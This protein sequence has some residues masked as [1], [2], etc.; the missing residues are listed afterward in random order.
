MLTL[1]V[2]RLMLPFASRKNGN[3]QLEAATVFSLAMLQ[4][5]RGKGLFSRQPQEKLSFVTSTAY[6]LWLFPRNNSGLIFDGLKR[7][8]HSVAYEEAPS[9]LAFMDN[10]MKNQRPRETFEAFLSDNNSYFQQ[11]PREKRFIFQGLI[12]D[13]FFKVEF[14]LYRKEATDL[15]APMTVLTP[16]LVEKH[17]TS[18]LSELDKLQALFREDAEKLPECSRF[19]AKT[20]GQYMTEIDYEAAAA[21][22]EAD[23]KIKALEEFINPQVAKLSKEYHRKI[24]DLTEGF[25]REIERLQKLKTKTEKSIASSEAKIRQ[26]EREAKASGKKGHEYYERHWKDKTKVTEKELSAI[27]KE[28]KNFENEIKGLSKQKGKDASELNFEMDSKIRL[29]RQPILDLEQARDTKILACKQESSRLLSIERPLLE[30]INRSI[31]LREKA[32]AVFEDLGIH[33]P[34]SKSP[35][36]FYVPFYLVCY[37]M[38]SARRYVCISPS[39]FSEANLSSKLKAALGRSK[40]K[41]ILTPRYPAIATLI[42]KVEKLPYQDS[43]FEGTL[44]SLGEKNNLLKNKEF[45]SEASEGL[46]I[47][48]GDNWLT[49]QEASEL[50]SQLSS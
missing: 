8:S 23:A 33:D 31:R 50:R 19:I 5:S 35:T 16:L 28:Y 40:I 43:L 21:K 12:A 22:D 3:P 37:E 17:I 7:V 11:P 25:D 47:L 1:P 34:Q 39:T 45:Q 14:N 48:R 10:L 42:S 36:L 32:N 27:K 2:K 13:P 24:K 18:T 44:W 29:M 4:R 9:A 49:E 46:R 6:P 38:D 15:A 20:T 41:D 30:G 26:Y